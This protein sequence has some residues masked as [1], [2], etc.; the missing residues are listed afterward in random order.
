MKYRFWIYERSEEQHFGDY[1]TKL[2]TL[3]NA[4]EFKEHENMIRDKIVFSMKDK[5]IQERVLKE[6]KLTLKRAVH[7]QR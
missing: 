2:R 6:V 4:C 3:A 5:R 1:T 7:L